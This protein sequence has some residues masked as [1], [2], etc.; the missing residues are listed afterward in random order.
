[1][2]TT[3][4][5]APEVQALGKETYNADRVESISQS[6]DEKARV[7][8]EDKDGVVVQDWTPEEERKVV[9]KVDFRLFPMLC[10]VFGLSLLDRANISAAF[11]AGMDEDLELTGARYNVALLVF[12]IGYGLFE[13]PSNYVIR[14]LG[15]RFWLSFLITTWGACVL[16]MGFVDDWR[17]LSVLRALLGVF[18]AGLFPGAI[19]IIG[20]WY[21]TYETAKR[22]SIFYMASLIAQGFGPI[23]AYALSLISV[24]NGKYT[25]GWRWIFIIEGLITIV[26]G[27]VSPF[28]LIEF[29]ER[30]RFLDE[31][32]K[33]IA[34]DRV[35]IDKAGKDIVHLNVRET[36][37]A[38]LDWKLALYCVQY[39]ISASS[40]YSLAFFAPIILRLGLGFSYTEAQLLSSPPY[41]FTIIMTIIMAWLSDKIKMRWPIQNAHCIIGVIGLLI[42]LYAGSNGARYFGLFLASWGAGALVPGTLTYGQNQTA[43]LEKKGVVAA[44][45]ISVGAIGG[46]CGSTIFRAQD[47]PFYYPGM[48]ATIAMLLVHAAITSGLSYYY[49][50]QNRKADREGKILE[51]VEGFRYAP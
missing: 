4:G 6:S 41:I 29:P 25:Q 23:F 44:A 20:S 50:V 32:Q 3:Y 33:Q 7:V 36:L 27:L 34:L 28:F 35:R 11:I 19:Y 24:G 26:A 1:M 49:K 30:V 37:A 21:R 51:G 38:L 15:A 10:V 39:F 17:I 43:R 48:W 18:E 13:L 5:V 22:I 46:V 47:R 45:M 40:V 16:G 9:K 8:A 31:R 2:S 14:R 42:M 12:F